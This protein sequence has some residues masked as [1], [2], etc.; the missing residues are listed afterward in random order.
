MYLTLILILSKEGNPGEEAGG[1]VARWA[2]VIRGVERSA[3]LGLR[4]WIE[5]EWPSELRSPVL[6]SAPPPPRLVSMKK[7]L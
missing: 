7:L 1:G 6:E 3:F 4:S 5:G 2:L